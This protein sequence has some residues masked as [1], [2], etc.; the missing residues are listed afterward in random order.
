MELLHP[1]LEKKLEEVIKSQLE[2]G[3]LPCKT[4]FQIALQ[5]NVSRQ[6]VGEVCNRIHIKFSRCQLGCFE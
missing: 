5:E 2:N 6:R 3:R 4:A 1:D